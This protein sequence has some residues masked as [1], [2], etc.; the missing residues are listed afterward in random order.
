M[1]T[2]WAPALYCGGYAAFCILCL[3]VSLA[4]RVDGVA[5]WFSLC[6]KRFRASVR[7]VFIIV[8]RPRVSDGVQRGSKTCSATSCQ[9][10][11]ASGRVAPSDFGR[12]GCAAEAVFAASLV[13]GE[14]TEAVA[15]MHGCQGI[16]RAF[17]CSF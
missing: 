17:A 10:L 14:G 16:L 8:S 15:S 9:L 3:A 13:S 6:R 4:R 2:G 11:E 7:N 1:G 12:F 5:M